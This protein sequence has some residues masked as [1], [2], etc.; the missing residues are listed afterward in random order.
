LSPK[1]ARVN[2][3]RVNK[4]KTRPSKMVNNYFE[5]CKCIKLHTL[6]E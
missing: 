6:W 5:F 1:E 4:K 3:P 2:K